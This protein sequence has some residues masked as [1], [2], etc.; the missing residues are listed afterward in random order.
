MRRPRQRGAEREGWSLRL[1]RLGRAGGGVGDR[2]LAVGIGDSFYFI[3]VV[4]GEEE[5]VG[6][7][8]TRMSLAL[9]FRSGRT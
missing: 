4:P 3:S 6:E 8:L 2:A 7:E 9:W 1:A 5:Q